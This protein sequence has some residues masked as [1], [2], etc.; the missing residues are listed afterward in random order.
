MRSS[1]TDKPLSLSRRS[2]EEPHDFSQ[3]GLDFISAAEYSVA[4][5][6]EMKPMNKELI[7]LL[8]NRINDVVEKYSVLKAENARLTGEI[9]RFSSEREGLKS[10]VDVILGKLEGI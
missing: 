5:R 9:E 2:G 3:L 8:E 1:R 7:E 4:P 10:R 6:K